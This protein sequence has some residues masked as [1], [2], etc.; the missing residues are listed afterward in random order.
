MTA[1]VETMAY[2]GEK[3]WHGI[4][5][6]VSDEL[7]PLEML[8]SAKL[9]WTVEKKN[10]YFEHEGRYIQA[11][12]K[13][14]VLVRSDNQ[15]VLGPAGPE[16]V[17]FQNAEVIDFYTKF[18]KAGH[19]KMETMG[20]LNEG[21]HIFA[22]AKLKDYF[23]IKGDD[24]TDAYLLISHPHEW[25][26]A[27][28]FLF[29]PIRVVCQNTLTMALGKNSHQYRVPHIQPFNDDIKL[30]VEEALGICSQQLKELKVRAEHLSG[31]QY[32]EKSLQEYVA[33]L[34]QPE[35]VGKKDI[36]GNFRPTADDVYTAIT[37]RQPRIKA[38]HGTWWEA[39]NG[40]T[41]YI[42]HESGRDRGKALESAWFGGKASIKRE[43]LALALE[44]SEK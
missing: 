12:Q 3:P 30:K 27:D 6:Q 4:G 24:K 8:K 43:A 26:K 38:T 14:H 41:W 19:M 34:Y 18:C 39:F 37:S 40:V 33:K 28:K 42:D 11:S 35:L 13:N 17:C 31:V 21:R 5:T 32:K 29:T 36:L 7:M 16:Y 25:G 10:V 22:L 2:A 44:H 23:V 15:M 20:S 9:D 1:N